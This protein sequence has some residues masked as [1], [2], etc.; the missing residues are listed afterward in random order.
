MYEGPEETGKLRESVANELGLPSG[1]PVAA[2]GGDNAAAAVGVGVI[3]EG[4]ISSSVGTS[5]VVFAHTGEFTPD[6][7]AA[8]HAFLS[9]CTRMLTI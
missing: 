8:L 4:V 3:Q 9:R 1:I 7:S 5:G 2:G 6:P